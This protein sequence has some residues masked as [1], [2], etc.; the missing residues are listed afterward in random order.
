MKLNLIILSDTFSICKFRTDSDI[1]GWIKDSDF[2]S[3]TRTEDELSI[4]CKQSDSIKDAIEIKK[5]WRIFKVSGPL[6]FSLT[7]IIAEISV[8]LKDENISVFTISTYETDYFLVKNVHLNSAV[9]SLKAN[10]HNVTYNN[11]VNYKNNLRSIT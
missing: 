6:D 10:G 8:I 9:N 3:L 5:D 2:Y 7:G 4:V 1:P 11:L